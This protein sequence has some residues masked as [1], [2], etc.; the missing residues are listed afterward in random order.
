M[1]TRLRNW[2]FDLRH[3]LANVGRTVWYDHSVQLVLLLSVLPWIVSIYRRRDPGVWLPLAEITGIIAVYWFF[4]RGRPIEPL[5]VRRPWLESGLVLVFALL[6]IG[7]RVLEYSHVIVFPAIHLGLCDDLMDT[8]IPKMI[9]MTLL[10]FILLLALGYS[11]KQQGI[12]L[13]LWAWV[14]ALI[15]LAIYIYWGLSHQSPLGLATR[16]VCFYF[17]AGLPEEFLFRAL[18]MSRL[19]A[20]TRRPVWGLFLG[21]FVFGVSHIPIDLQGSGLSNWPNALESA[22]TF[23]M[24]I[25]L[26]LGYAFLRCR[27]IWPLT[28]IHALIDSAP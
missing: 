21:A 3:D 28:F 5:P 11:L 24:S 27:N 9:E 2:F 8:I 16:G 17:G 13:P 15:P 26:A 1:V 6:W 18:I 7:Y 22:F 23:Q 20:L 25:G 4:T 14:P 19:E 12:G 10:P